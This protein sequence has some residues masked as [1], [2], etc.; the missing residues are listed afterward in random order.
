M[1]QTSFDASNVNWQV[2]EAAITDALDKVIR[3]DFDTK[4]IRNEALQAHLTIYDAADG[5]RHG[6]LVCPTLEEYQKCI[7]LD[8]PD[9]SI[10]LV[11]RPGGSD[12]NTE[13][14]W[15]DDHTVGERLALP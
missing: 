1:H 15:K 10:R 5:R 6:E 7:D 13:Q 2:L 9:F 8:F 4:R 12:L 14:V 11:Q 3:D